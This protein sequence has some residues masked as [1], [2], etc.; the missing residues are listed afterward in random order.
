M[1]T[2]LDLYFMLYPPALIAQKAG[3][4]LDAI[5][6]PCKCVSAPMPPDRM[7]MTLQALG[8]YAQRVPVSVLQMGRTVGGMVDQMPF[9]LSLDLLQSRSLE[10][11]LGT[12]EL[13]GRG[14]VRSR[15]VNSARAAQR[16]R[17]ELRPAHAGHPAL[18]HLAKRV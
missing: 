11:S 3:R 14:T 1:G 4:L 7:H 17:L 12:V 18:L 8:R 2:V 10:R 15:C 16:H 5:D 6:G 9:Q 13:A